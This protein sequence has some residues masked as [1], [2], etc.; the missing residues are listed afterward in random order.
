[1]MLR[2]VV[3]LPAPFLPMIVTT[4]PVPTVSDTPWRMC[5]SP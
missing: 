1:M 4:S 5:A 2:K 3:V